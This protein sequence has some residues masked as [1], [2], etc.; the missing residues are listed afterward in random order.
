M[1]KHDVVENAQFVSYWV[2]DSKDK[3]KKL[4]YCGYKDMHGNVYHEEI[5]MEEKLFWEKTYGKIP[6]VFSSYFCVIF[7]SL[8]VLPLSCRLVP[9]FCHNS[10][11][12]CSQ[13]R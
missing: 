8:P 11:S 2:D 6:Y 1:K 9:A 10:L 7:I 13:C 5:T 4:C 12:A 3:N